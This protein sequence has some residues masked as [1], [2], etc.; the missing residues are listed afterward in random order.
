[1]PHIRIS[2]MI[3]LPMIVCFLFLAAL[4]ARAAGGSTVT[5]ESGGI[6][7]TITQPWSLSTSAESDGRDDLLTLTLYDEDEGVISGGGQVSA[8]SLQDDP[9]P[10][11]EDV[12]RMDT[13]ELSFLVDYF[14][15][16]YV[17]DSPEDG[18]GLPAVEEINGFAAIVVRTKRNTGDASLHD[19]SFNYYFPSASKYVYLSLGMT[20]DDAAGGLLERI[21]ASFA[22]RT[23]SPA[24]MTTVRSDGMGVSCPRSWSASAGGSIND[25]TWAILE[26][27]DGNQ[28]TIA[29]V[30]VFSPVAAG[31]LPM[32]MEERLRAA[33]S[34]LGTGADTK[35][36]TPLGTKQTTVGDFPATLT[37]MRVVVELESVKPAIVELRDIAVDDRIVTIATRYTDTLSEKDNEELEAVHA[38]FT[39]A[40]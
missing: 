8:Y 27:E 2:A 1:M 23:S 31:T 13:E 7:I 20:G 33:H 6:R 39:W 25:P 3:H 40:P 14:T 22:P 16:N 34:I 9:L 36:I 28:R 12:R 4:P 10:N 5:V 18:A 26:K 24:D 19:F 30:T 11:Q 32:G 38:S 37:R 35:S 21:A 29:S 15:K 17:K